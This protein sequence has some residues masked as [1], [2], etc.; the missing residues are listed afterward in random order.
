MPLPKVKFPLFA[1]TLVCLLW[2]PS[3]SH[4]KNFCL[5]DH[6]TLIGSLCVSRSWVLT[7]ADIHDITYRPTRYGIC[8]VYLVIQ[9]HSHEDVWGIR[10]IHPRILN[11]GITWRQVISFTLR[12]FTSGTGAPPERTFGWPTVGMHMVAKRRISALA[13]K[14]ILVVQPL[15]SHYTDWAILNLNVGR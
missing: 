10:E 5:S 13:A 12:V 3:E 11:L 8:K 7:A 6:K 9:A 4:T 15:A 1:Y 2:L 14:G